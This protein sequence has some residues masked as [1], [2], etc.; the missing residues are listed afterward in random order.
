MW[1]AGTAEGATVNAHHGPHVAQVGRL[2]VVA[3]PA[4]A[5][6]AALRGEI[7]EVSV[8]VSHDQLPWI[9]SS[10]TSTRLTPLKLNR[11]ST[12]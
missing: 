4:L 2:A 9:R 1:R 5:K 7:R 12:L 10:G 8:A 3:T 11:S 6:D